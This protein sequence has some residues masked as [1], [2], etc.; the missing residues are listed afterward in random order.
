MPIGTN[1]RLGRGNARREGHEEQAAHLGQAD[2]YIAR[3]LEVRATYGYL[4]NN[5]ATAAS[6][7][8]SSRL[9]MVW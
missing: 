4:P 7:C 1:R 6:A 5:S 2:P 9:R 8:A 3:A